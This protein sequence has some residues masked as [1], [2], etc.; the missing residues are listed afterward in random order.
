[1]ALD[2][3]PLIYVSRIAAR[4][5]SVAVQDGYQLYRHAFLFLEGRPLVQLDHLTA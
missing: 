4:V 2:P 1:M 3:G 5:D